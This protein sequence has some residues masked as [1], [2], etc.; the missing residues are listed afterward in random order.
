MFVFN[1]DNVDLA[2]E[3]AYSVLAHE[4]Q[5]MIHWYTDANESTW[6]NEGFSV[7]AELL[8]EKKIMALVPPSI[9]SSVPTDAAALDTVDV[10]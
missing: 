8:K 1:A 4:F 10:I 5:H 9:V 7:V 3:E 6:M 2:S